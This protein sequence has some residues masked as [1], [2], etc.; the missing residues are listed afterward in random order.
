MPVP[1]GASGSGQ[2][3]NKRTLIEQLQ[4]HDITWTPRRHALI[5]ACDSWTDP[6]NVG[7]AFRLADAF[8]VGE[9]WLGGSTPAPPNQKLNRAARSS[10]RWQPYRMVP[11]FVPAL[12][13]AQ[14]AGSV[15]IG[16]EITDKSQPLAQLSV[17]RQ[18]AEQPIL[19]VGAERAGIRKEVL[20]IL[21]YCVHIEMHGRNSSLN[22]A[23]ALGIALYEWNR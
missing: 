1:I 3:Y 15:L 22:V 18:R 11:E 5:V 20:E 12:L 13:A 2:W 9:L 16:L 10:Q 8:G 6:R 23:T 19:V 21:D 17:L 14:Q 4:H 7:M